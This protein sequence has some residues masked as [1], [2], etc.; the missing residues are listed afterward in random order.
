MKF[1][2]KSEIAIHMI[3]NYSLI[4]VNYYLGFAVFIKCLLDFMN[5]LS[6]C[7]FCWTLQAVL[8]MFLHEHM[9]LQIAALYAT[10]VFCH[11][12]QFPKGKYYTCFY[13]WIYRSLPCTLLKSSVTLTSS[14]KVNITHVSTHE[15]TDRCPVRNSSSVTLTSSQKLNIGSDSTIKEMLSVQ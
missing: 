12:H 13:T 4:W 11:T 2:S 5:I 14:Q 9:N 10:Q 3:L 7:Y 8:Q 1:Y 15:S 6:S